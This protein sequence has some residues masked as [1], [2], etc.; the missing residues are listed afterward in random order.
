MND[1]RPMPIRS[2]RLFW[3]AAYLGLAMV[4]IATILVQSSYL[5]ALATSH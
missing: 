3:L 5:A 2:I 4:L 1:P